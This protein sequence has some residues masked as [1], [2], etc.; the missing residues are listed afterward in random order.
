MNEQIKTWI[1]RINVMLADDH[2]EAQLVRVGRMAMEQNKD[3]L[4]P[5]PYVTAGSGRK[6]LKIWR[7]RSSGSQTIFC[8]IRLSDG[9]IMRAE[10]IKKPAKHARGSIFDADVTTACYR[11]GAKYMPGTGAGKRATLDA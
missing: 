11:Y 2:R 3:L 5:A 9:A 8:F 4:S 10:S 6:Y 7:T 1:D